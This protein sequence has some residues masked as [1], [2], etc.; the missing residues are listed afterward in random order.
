VLAFEQ[1]ILQKLKGKSK[2]SLT[3][4]EQIVLAVEALER[5][6]NN[7]GY[8]QFFVNSS[9]EFA[10]IIVGA[11]RRLGCQKT[12]TITQKALDALGT[13]DLRS[14]A[15]E[16]VIC[17]RDEKRSAKLQRCDDSYY[18]NAEP[19]AE[20]LLEFIKENKASISL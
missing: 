13:T 16:N 5:E 1:G 6:V 19:I 15:I 7:G 17:V 18:K 8:D 3:A 20:R 9:R 14:D 4:E 2:E 11:L 10:A 12:A